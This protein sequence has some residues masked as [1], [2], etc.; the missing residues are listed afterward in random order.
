MDVLDCIRSRRSVRRFVDIPIE[1]SKIGE[2]LDAGR[3][4]PSAGNLQSWRF[5]LV[6]DP[7]KRM[8]VADACLKQ[9]WIA[10]A[11]VIIVIVAEAGETKS[12]Y[13]ERGE[14]LFIIQN[15]AA[16]AQNMLLAAHA[17]GLASCWVSAFEEHQLSSVLDV[18]GDHRIQA[19]LPIG[20][21]DEKPIEPAKYSLQALTFFN[22]FGARLEDINAVLGD[23]SFHVEKAI[24][25]GSIALKRAQSVIKK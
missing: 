19:V 11:P 5:I 25:K 22:S 6:L 10:D 24:K 12:F 7:D 13:G 16:A 2:I 1:M 9:D 14:K 17:R 23:Y 20:Y 3:L 8:A 4:A 15:C 18:P 21:P